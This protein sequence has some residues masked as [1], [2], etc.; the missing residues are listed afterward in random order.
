MELFP[1]LILLVG[2]GI[3]LGL[4]I[5][6]RA[7]AFLA[8]IVAAFVVSILAPGTVGEKIGRVATAFG[9][10]AGSIGIVIAL[11]AL[12]GRLMMDSGA[13]D[14][15]V[16]FFLSLLGEK[17]G[18]T[19]LSVSGYMLS[20][21]VFFDTVFYL[22]VPLA[23][24]MFRRTNRNYLKYL[25]AITAGGVVTHT[26]VPP[27]PGPLVMAD[28]LNVSLGVMIVAGALI[29]VPA[30]AIGLAFAT[31]VDHR[32][33]ISMR[34]LGDE[35]PGGPVDD[36]KLPSLFASVLPILL[37]IVLVTA[38]SVLSTVANAERVA[39]FK[40]G[41]ITNWPAF[42]TAVQAG[43]SRPAAR[44]LDSLPE[45][46]RQ[47]IS[48]LEPLGPAGEAEVMSG[49]NAVLVNRDFYDYETFVGTSLSGTC[50][51]LLKGNRQRMQ[52]ATLEHLNRLLIEASF[53]QVRPHVWDTPKRRAAHAGD[54]FGD[55]NFALLLAT[56]AAMGVYLRQRRPTREQMTH[57]VESALMSG[58]VIILITAAGGAFGAMLGQ[59]QIGPAVQGLF[60]GGN[61]IGKL[62]LLILA[63][64]MASLLKFAQGSSTVAMI[65]AA[66]MMAAMI[67]PEALGFHPV[68]LATAVGSGSLVGSWM[69]DSG[70]WIFCKMGGLTEAETL[71]SWTP[72]LAV[73][74]IA[75]MTF[76]VV[77]AMIFPMSAG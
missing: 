23:R 52:V 36:S 4:I 65:T 74:G 22:L 35:E 18:A 5:G 30:A 12:I 15:I 48:S 55:P 42:V 60:G 28:T 63:F 43:D 31:W 1:L 8:L 24:S 75:A 47:R 6:L 62:G 40:P 68:Y 54:F 67:N 71:R 33:P 21:P 10:V 73:C 34:P 16:L 49:L 72:L 56:V 53:P 61:G 9:G 32:M 58:G 64:S 2:I 66:G 29:G 26:L 37:P 77:L 57:A 59:A 19:A 70:F 45:A 50:R 13:A 11:A 3:V 17:R 14:R 39:R 44:L 76:T 41:D 51:D 20:I 38:G 27:T 69:N 46:A 25:M 7:N